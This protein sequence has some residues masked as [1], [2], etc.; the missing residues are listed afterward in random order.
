MTVAATTSLSAGIASG[1]VNAVT[2]HFLKTYTDQ[3]RMAADNTGDA[4]A[5]EVIC[6]VCTMSKTLGM[7]VSHTHRKTS[8]DIEAIMTED[9]IVVTSNEASPLDW[10]SI[11]RWAEDFGRAD[12]VRFVL[13]DQIVNIDGVTTLTNTA[14]DS[15]AWLSSL[16]SLLTTKTQETATVTTPSVNMTF[17]PARYADAAIID[18]VTA[19]RTALNTL[20]NTSGRYIL[21]VICP[22]SDKDNTKPS[23][24]SKKAFC[25]ALGK[26]NDNFGVEFPTWVDMTIA[27]TSDYSAQIS[28]KQVDTT[29]KTG[30]LSFYDPAKSNVIAPFDTAVGEVFD[31]LWPRATKGDILAAAATGAASTEPMIQP[32]QVSMIMAGAAVLAT[33]GYVAWI[34]QAAEKSE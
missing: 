5:K 28:T 24:L 23:D 31:G 19:Y 27:Y 3:F 4:K 13:T 15:L 14:G 21:V 8:Q 22:P 16:S 34:K 29:K 1:V 33:A 30:I 25:A 10:I 11:I 18:G 9:R 6:A 17:K 26:P 12:D 20:K 2:D 7:T 32:D